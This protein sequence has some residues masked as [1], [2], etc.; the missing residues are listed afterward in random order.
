MQTPKAVPLLG[1]ALA[2]MRLG[3]LAFGGM[4]STLGLLR[5]DLGA[6][7]GWITDQDVAEALAI[8]QTLP[9]STGVQVV[10]FLGWKLAGWPG[11]LIAPFSFV[12]VPAVMMIAASAAAGAL[13]EVPAVR[14]ALLGIQIAV[15]GV[16]AA[17]MLKMAG[18]TAKGRVLS[19][20]LAG[21][22]LIGALVSAVVAV[23]AMG[24]LGAFLALRKAKGARIG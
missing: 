19:A 7:R 23:L 16:L 9:G 8:T 14:G 5:S 10:A 24:A 21:G 22:M 13:P 17:N 4:G 1:L 20:V 3:S 6:R 11:A 15:V 12:M 2:L 18:S